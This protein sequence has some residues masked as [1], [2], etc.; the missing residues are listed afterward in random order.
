MEG[1]GESFGGIAQIDVMD[2]DID[3]LDEAKESD[4][5]NREDD[6]KADAR[7]TVGGEDRPE[8]DDLEIHELA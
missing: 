4:D 7:G 1:L 2:I 6:S 3:A 5:E 8:I